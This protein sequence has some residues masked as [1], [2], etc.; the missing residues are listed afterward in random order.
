MRPSAP[1]RRALLLLAV[2]LVLA[3]TAGERTLGTVTDEQQMLSTA[4][5]IAETGGLGVARGQF[6]SVPRPGGDALAPYG[7]GLPLVEVPFVLVAGPW[8]RVFGPRSSQTLLAL[9]PVLLV[10]AAA[11]G[12]GM[13]ARA[14]GASGPGEAVAVVG[15]ALSSPLWGYTST[16]Y[17]EPL[18]AACIALAA[19]L[20]AGSLRA[21]RRGPLLAG[22]AGLAAG[23]A[24]LVKP[25]N[26][27]LLPF[28]LA[29]VLLDAPVG[30]KGR[31][32]AVMAWSAGAGVTLVAWL[33]LEV[34][35]FGRPF[36]SYA[37]YG[38]THPFPDGLWRLVVGANEG[39]LWYF[40]LGALGAAGTWRLLRDRAGRGTGV[41]IA[42]S[43]AALLAIASGWWSWDGIVGWGPRLLVPAVPL[44]AA[45]A[46]VAADRLRR[47]R[48]VA[49]ALLLAGLA[50]N[51]LGALQSDA[52]RGYY[53][54]TTPPAVI[55][56]AQVRHFPPSVVRRDAEGRPRVPRS[57]VAALDAAFSPIRLHAFLIGA[58]LGSSSRFE[59]EERL[60]RPPWLAAHPEARPKLGS[61]PGTFSEVLANDLLDGFR[62]PHLFS[63]LRAGDEERRAGYN[64][65]WGVALADQVNRALDTGRGSQAVSLSAKLWAAAPSG[66]SAAMRAE[67]LRF[68]GRR[69]E[70]LAF[71]GA[72]P[73]GVSASPLVALEKALVARDVGDAAGGAI[74][75]E[76][77]ALA[78][79]SPAVRRA[80]GR[81]MEEW[82]L[83]LR[84][85]LRLAQGPGDPAVSR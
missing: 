6:F 52:S 17:T 64:G 18:Q 40:P 43:F 25:V 22:I 20:S 27:V 72:L 19:A 65:A 48:L 39:I 67:A 56:E 73:A 68:S 60:G 30:G 46:G 37:D 36:A 35:R 63:I 76:Q 14:A 9:L 21:V 42:G 85:F 12:A 11:G 7:M 28:L 45:A 44:L 70:L 78:I 82:P 54:D 51:L 41:A 8:E 83:G 57:H 71:L 59:A 33:A 15:T 32:P 75:M 4:V 26:L 74:L 66:F 49:S 31:R 5:A 69:D 58:R 77:A 53:L 23:T 79:P 38:F 55:S 2:F 34:A 61:L 80:R 29:P 62:W 50:V 84:D 13:L 10:T 24:V 16:L 81:P 3:G 47:G 1:R